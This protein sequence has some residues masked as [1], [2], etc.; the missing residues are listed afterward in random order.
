MRTGWASGGKGDVAFNV[1]SSSSSS[2]TEE[3]YQSNVVFMIHWVPPIH[4]FFLDVKVTRLTA[5]DPGCGT[6]LMGVK[7]MEE[8]GAGTVD[9]A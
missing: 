2:S 7:G 4:Q 9:I 5:T 6:G 1:F 3:K 8:L